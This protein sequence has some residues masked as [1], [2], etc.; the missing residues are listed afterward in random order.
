MNWIDI[1][2]L[3]LLA[4]AVFNGIRQGL[5]VQ[6]CSML[7]L[8]VG[9]WLGFRGGSTLGGWFGVEQ[10]YAF[11]VGFLV[12][13]LTTIIVVAIVS[14]LIKKLFKAVGLGG[15]DGG[16]GALLSVCKYLLIMTLLFGAFESLNKSFD[17]VN[18]KTINSS[19]SYKVVKTIG[20]ILFP[21]LDWTK[22]QIDS[23]LEK[24]Q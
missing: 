13:F 18:P 19:K 22:K 20:G 23:G 11:I 15:L 1:V 7:A 16:L 10:N 4:F 6:V 14:R 12:I 24:L 17:I 2:I 3:L 9:I 5:I 8:I 21:T